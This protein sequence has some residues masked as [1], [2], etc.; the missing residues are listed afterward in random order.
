MIISHYKPRLAFVFLTIVLGL[1]GPISAQAAIAPVKQV[2]TSYFGWEVNAT[3]KA[4]ICTI[5]S[6]DTCQPGTINSAPGGFDYPE[7][8]AG[9]P[10]PSTNFYVLDRGNNRVQEFEADGKFVL[11]FGKNV[12]K[13]GSNLCTAA[14][15]NECQAGVGGN[16][17]GQFAEGSQSIVVDPT[18]GN[19]YVAET[20]P[21]AGARVQEFTAAGVFVL[22]IGREV[23]E[24]KDKEAGAT[25]AEKNVCTQEEI[26]NSNVKCTAPVAGSTLEPGAFNFESG[27]NILAVGGPEELLYVGDEH[28]VQEFNAKTGVTD[29]RYKNEISLASISNNPG[30]GVSSLALDRT[31]G[32]IY[33]VYNDN[34]GLIR[35]FDSTGKEI[36]SLPVTGNV[37]ALAVDSQGRLAVSESLLVSGAPVSR[38]SLYEVGAGLHLITRF[39]A[40]G[41]TDLAF[42]SKDSMY[43]VLGEELSL[44]PARQEVVSYEPVP[45]AELLVGKAVCVPGPEHETDATLDCSLKGEVDPFGVSETEVWFKWGR[46]EL[47]G[48]ETVKRPIVTGNGLVGVNI[49]IAE[50]LPGE[51]LFDRLAGEDRNVKAPE[52]PLTS[53]A[54]E[55]LLTPTVPPRIVGVPIEGF[56]TPTSAV[57]FGGVNPENTLTRYEFQYAPETGCE[58]RLLEEGED[59]TK[60]CTGVSETSGVQSAEYGQIVTAQEASALQPS[61]R[62]RYRLYATNT[63]G[64]GATGETGSPRIPEGTFETAAPTVVSAQTGAAN[65]ITSTSALISGTVNPDGVPS[66]YTFEIGVYNAANTRY[67]TVFSASAGESTTPVFEELALTGLQPG[68]TYAYRITIH[69]GD[70]TTPGSLA[71]GQAQTFTTLGL[72]AVLLSPPSLALLGVP[73]I[74][75]PV[76]RKPAVVK[77]ATKCARGKGF[78]RGK[79]VK[80]KKTIKAHRRKPAR[81]K[82]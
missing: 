40:H 53:S 57:L 10:A 9:A 17:P 60:A 39:P 63:Q 22:E 65:T 66:A 73:T 37:L 38:G 54:V 46:S 41:A 82:K 19:L 74:A 35:E 81:G 1:A 51:K 64:Q 67:G 76:E 75:F 43:G 44:D 47:L 18:S 4:K 26:K 42:N 8:V 62:Y 2:A 59:L 7:S 80:S 69:F 45:V 50:V 32:D 79:C 56:A 31:T 5:A 48:S 3:T 29:G 71:I 72:P 11:M 21:T 27:A 58:K 36:K 20:F 34:L 24:T 14:E 68:T 25:P 6:G 13:K 16:A 30:V 49:P 23:N 55:E 70:A 12:N 77:K 15:E 33:L 61:T 52:E 28:R 78:V